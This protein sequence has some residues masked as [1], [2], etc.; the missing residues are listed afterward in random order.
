LAVQ[1]RPDREPPTAPEEETDGRRRRAQDS[2]RRIVEAMLA[3]VRESGVLPSAEQ[4]ASRAGV[5]LRTVFRQFKDMDSLYAEMSQVVEQGL[6]AVA[7]KPFASR[8]WRGRLI[9]MVD[10]RS[11]AFEQLGPIKRAADAQRAA[12]PFLTERHVR[13]VTVMRMLLGRALPPDI[14]ADTERFEALDLLLSFETWWRLRRDQGLSFDQARVVL[15]SAVLKVANG[16]RR[17]PAAQ[18]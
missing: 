2:R 3:L 10:R 13:L 16:G 11:G 7:A 8:A 6:W 18:D 9:E 4:V 14:A 5:G 17:L 1:D 12:S 15:R